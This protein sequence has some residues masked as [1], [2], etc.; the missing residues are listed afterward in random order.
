MGTRG[1]THNAVYEIVD[2]MFHMPLAMKQLSL[3]QFCSWFAL[4]AMWIYS[5]AAVTSVSTP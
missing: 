2:D 3:V 5:T 4:F 1:R